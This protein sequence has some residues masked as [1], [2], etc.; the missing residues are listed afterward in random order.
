MVPEELQIVLIYPIHKKVDKQLCDNYRGIALLNV[1]YKVLSKCILDRIKPWA[2]DILGDYQAGFRQNRSNTD[3]IFILKQTFQKMWEFNR[4]V[5]ILFIDFKKA[6]DCIHR[7]SLLN[8]LRQLKSSQKL[9]NL[10]KVNILHTEIKIKVDNIVSKGI[11]VSTGLRQRDA[12]SPIL[13]N[14]ALEKIIRESRIEENKVR[15]DGCLIE[16]LAYGDD[17]VILVEN[18]E[19][20]KEQAIKLLDTAKR[21]SLKINA[22]KTEYMIVQR[23][24]LAD[25]VRPFLKIGQH[26]F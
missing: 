15:L 7:E 20:L 19:N 6:Y 11:P 8:V 21:I 14:I 26:R 4:E 16:V 24:E 5:H 1:S 12:L 25:H 10:I 3:Q 13:F 2:D 9:I 23:R 17:I 18:K 22:E